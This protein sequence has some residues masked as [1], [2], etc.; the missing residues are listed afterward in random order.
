MKSAR[1]RHTGLGW[2]TSL[3]RLFITRATKVEATDHGGRLE[4]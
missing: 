3:V 2:T 4:A 1:S